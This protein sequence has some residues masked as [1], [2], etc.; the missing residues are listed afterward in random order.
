VFRVGP[1]ATLGMWP[2]SHAE[3]GSFPPWY[4]E[5]TRI[6]KPFI[7]FPEQEAL[8]RIPC[9]DFSAV[10]LVVLVV[11]YFLRRPAAESFDSMI[12]VRPRAARFKFA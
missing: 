7:A 2:A 6:T 1:L 10:L 3:G 12:V 9:R 5:S 11:V 8:P 4:G